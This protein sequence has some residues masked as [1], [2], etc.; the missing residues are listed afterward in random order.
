M[1]AYFGYLI[2]VSICLLVFYSF[3]Q[4]V[5]RQRTFFGLNR[6]Y[7]VFGLLLSFLIPVLK[8]SI[9]QGPSGGMLTQLLHPMVF[10]PE[11][12]FFQPQNS[13]AH[14]TQLNFPILL[15]VVYFAGII[16]LFSKLL[17]SILR[18]VRIRKQAETYRMGRIIVVKT[19]ATVPFSF[20]NL[21]FLPKTESNPLIIEHEMAHIKQFH[22]FD[23]T[24]TEM[25]ALLLWFNP[26]VVLYKNSL[27][28]Q[29]EYLADSSVIKNSHE[30]ENYL[31]C[32]LNRIQAVSYG[33]LISHFYCK[34][35]KKRIVMITKNKT[36][37]SYLGMYLLA[38][39]LVAFLL[40]AFTTHK[41]NVVTSTTNQT[42]VD[43]GDDIPSIYPVD[44]KKVTSI[45]GYG[46]RINP[47]YKNKEFHYAVDLALPEGE[48]VMA[49]A[50]GVVLEVSFDDRQGNYVVIK[51]SEE[52]TTVYTKLKSAQ[53][54]VGDVVDK[55]QQIGFV[56]STGISTG[57]HLHYVVQKNGA[58]VNPQD[59]FPK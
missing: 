45:S 47:L 5:L 2:E 23:L 57:P 30:M 39:P 32:L 55:G 38:L 51:H 29:H 25:A 31:G 21:I 52:Y 14:A 54:K 49:T 28:L 10:E 7:L 59:Y 36:S 9:F 26:F 19:E 13:N 46:E 58:K 40:F 6:L 12:D 50:K 42:L 33:G 22:W 18:I 53:I 8:I 41:S 17:F 11:T 27:K 34:T 48:S 24:I 56:G 4:L 43:N 37:V 44:F 15:A 20:F 16:I 3:Y 35:F 1:P